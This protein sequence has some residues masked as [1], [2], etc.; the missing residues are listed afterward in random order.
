MMSEDYIEIDPATVEAEK[1]F[2]RL[3]KTVSRTANR[4]VVFSVLWLGGIG[5]VFAVYFGFKCLQLLK[6]HANPELKGRGKAIFGIT[7]GI[8]GVILFIAFWSGLITGSGMFDS[9]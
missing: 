2:I 9:L 1:K 4:A 5:S 6:I 8:C 3:Q 7:L